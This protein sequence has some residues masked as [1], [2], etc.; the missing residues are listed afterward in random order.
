MMMMMMLIMVDLGN[1]RD[2]MQIG[3]ICEI[4]FQTVTTVQGFR[5]PGYCVGLTGTGR[6][7]IVL[8]SITLDR[9]ARCYV[10]NIN[11]SMTPNN[12]YATTSIPT[13]RPTVAKKFLSDSSCTKLQ[14]YLPPV[15]KERNIWLLRCLQKYFLKK[16]VI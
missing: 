3:L 13:F 7:H 9:H 6:M 5:K 11:E 14:K 16:E 10:D 1:R 15:S 8:C 4:N 2:P 12:A